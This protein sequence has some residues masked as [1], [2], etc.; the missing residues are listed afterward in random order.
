MTRRTGLNRRTLL[1]AA[2]TLPL[3][4]SEIASAAAPA[5][6]HMAG[7]EELVHATMRDLQIPGITIGY[8]RG[9]A[10]WVR[11]YGFADL[12]NGVPATSLSA[13]RYASVQKPMTAVA[14]LQLVERGRIE[15]DADVR[16]Y[17]PYFPRKAYPITIRQ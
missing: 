13:Y 14:V 8:G 5:L 16:Q 3:A 4:G 10:H 15:L 9:E 1:G 17:V 2:A 11:G 7:F 6:P 12:E